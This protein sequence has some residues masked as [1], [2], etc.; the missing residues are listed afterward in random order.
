MHASMSAPAPSVPYGVRAQA[1]RLGRGDGRHAEK[2]RGAQSARII[3]SRTV[4]SV[5]AQNLSQGGVQ[6][7]VTRVAGVAHI[8]Q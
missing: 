5:I 7:L 3:P 1:A 6:A 8:V 2:P 4:V